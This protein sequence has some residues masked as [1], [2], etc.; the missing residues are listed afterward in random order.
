MHIGNTEYQPVP[1]S[2]I[3]CHLLVEKHSFHPE[4]YYSDNENSEQKV[5]IKICMNEIAI[6]WHS[7]ASL[8]QKVVKIPITVHKHDIIS[9]AI[10]VVC[11]ILFT[12]YSK[13]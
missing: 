1:V 11:I 2:T 13:I 10:Q 7:H 4:N 12:T 6:F 9:V 5:Q 3:L 8:F